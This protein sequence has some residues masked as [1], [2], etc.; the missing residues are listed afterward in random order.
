MKPRRLLIVAALL[1]GWLLVDAPPAQAYIGP[2]AGF[3]FVG[4]FFI[5][6]ATLFLA[7][8]KLATAPFRLLVQAIRWRKAL[9]S[10]RVKQVVILG[11]DG[12][13]PELTDGFLKEGILPNFEKLREQGS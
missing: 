8:V 7:F 5:V 9:R 4:S 10:S 12:Q 1:V 2:G 3:A 11:L 13:D 6:F